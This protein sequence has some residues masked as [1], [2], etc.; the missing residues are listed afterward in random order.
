MKEV[1]AVQKNPFSRIR[2][3]YRRTSITVKTLVLATLVLCSL[4][5]IT[6][7]FSLMETKKELASV[8]AEAQMLEQE[9][10]RLQK[11][12]RQLGTVQS[13]TDLAEELLGL[14]DPNTVIFEA[15]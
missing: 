9:N 15:E 10:D 6:L 2:L 12:I 13:V 11:S 3:V 4:T 7:R 8:R 1:T 14:V 5:L